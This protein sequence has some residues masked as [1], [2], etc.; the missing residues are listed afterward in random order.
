MPLEGHYARQSTPLYELSARELKAATG[1]LVVTLV[2]ILAVVLFT[3]DDSRPGPEKGCIAPTVA[4]IVG[5]ETLGACGQEA[6]AVC[7]HAAGFSGERAE[8]ILAEC[9]AQEVAF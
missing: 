2:A 4:G 1:A 7:Q 9:R 3:V 5:A 6:V 8:T